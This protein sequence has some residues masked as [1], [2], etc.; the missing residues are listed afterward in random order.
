MFVIKPGQLNA[1]NA[2]A[3][4]QYE[5][6]MVAHIKT[7]FPQFAAEHTN[8]QLLKVV[9]HAIAK[10]KHYG[11]VSRKNV[12]ILLNIMLLHGENF[13]IDPSQHWAVEIL[14]DKTI[15]SADY[16]INALR[17]KSRAILQNQRN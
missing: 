17:A 5:K 6:E 13:D 3:L 12:C 16:R 15:L 14:T 7:F 8:E 11:F 4:L 10:G 1:F 9:R 2:V